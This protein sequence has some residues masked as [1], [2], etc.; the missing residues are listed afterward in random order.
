MAAKAFDQHAAGINWYC[1]T[2][3][4]G[5]SI[6]LIPSGEGDCAS[7]ARTA[8]NLAA[9]FS[10]LTFDMPG[11]SRSGPPPNWNVSSGNV[12]RQIASLTTSL[13]VEHATFY[14][15]SSGGLFALAL[16]AEHPDLVD[17]AVVHE[18]AIPLGSG[19]PDPA[20]PFAKLFSPDDKTVVETCKLLFRSFMNENQKAWDDLGADY[21]QRLEINYL[22]WARRYVGA[23]AT[24]GFFRAFSRQDLTRR[25][26]TWTVGSITGGGPILEGNRKIADIG[27]IAI[28]FLSCKHF[29]QVSIP[30]LLADHIRMSAR[31]RL[32]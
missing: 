10:V 19:S 9:D 28:E 20:N 14:G 27:G 31:K 13:G 26:V 1:E 30:D 32:S 11:F 8:D 12:A 7:F 17:S 3:G 23:S 24:S 16:A 22:T 4:S 29:P 25:P 15:C 5:P 21:H 2:R 18:V 6:V